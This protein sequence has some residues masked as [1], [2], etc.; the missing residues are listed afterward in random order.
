MEV[1]LHQNRPHIASPFL[2]AAVAI[3]VAIF[4]VAVLMVLERTV[5]FWPAH[6]YALVAMLL[7]FS[8]RT[9][10]K[11]R[12]ARMRKGRFDQKMHEPEEALAV[13][14]PYLET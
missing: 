4:V 14:L 2:Y 6:F 5:P 1:V 10:I 9:V 8:C 7:L 13:A 3:L 12:P 11:M